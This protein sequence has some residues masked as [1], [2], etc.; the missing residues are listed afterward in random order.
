MCI[1]DRNKVAR[2]VKLGIVRDELLGYHA[3]DFPAAQHR[4]NVEQLA[5]LHERQ[6]DH[7]GGVQLSRLAAHGVERGKR[8]VQ[9]RA[10]QKQVAAGVSGQ[11]QFG[12]HDQMRALCRGLLCLFYDLGS[13]I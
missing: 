1:R 4:G 8:A 2:F 9:Q 13:I 3:L 11:A 6:A 10:L 12:E 5:L 7:H